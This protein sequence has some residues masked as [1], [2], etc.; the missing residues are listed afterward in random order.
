MNN[1]FSPFYFKK[2]L[3]ATPFIQ[4]KILPQILDNY[5]ADPTLSLDWNAHSSYGMEKYL[6]NQIDPSFLIQY[7]EAMIYD[8]FIDFFGE[9]VPFQIEENPWYN[10]YS[11]KQSGPTHEHIDADFSLIHYLKFNPN[12]HKGTT[13]LNPN[14]I[15]MKYHSLAKPNLV[16][17]LN[18]YNENQSMYFHELRPGVEEGDV[19]IFPSSLEHRIDPSE[20]DE[21]RIVVSL[22]FRIL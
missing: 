7:Y 4:S 17:K 10:V 15:S 21:L 20:T 1:I 14:R 2:R 11:G 6:K 19:L 18:I 3:E 22:N 9:N 13:F 16:S 5:Q 12:V 8:F